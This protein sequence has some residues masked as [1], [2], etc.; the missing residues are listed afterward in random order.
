MKDAQNRCVRKWRKV[1]VSKCMQ[2]FFFYLKK[3]EQNIY[4]RIWKKVNESLKM[5][6]EKLKKYKRF[7]KIMKTEDS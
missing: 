4:V 6:K 5:K 2:S 1:K 7:K 3:E